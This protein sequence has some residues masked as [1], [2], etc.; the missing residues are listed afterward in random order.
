[1][2][3]RIRLRFSGGVEAICKLR[4]EEAAEK[5][6]EAAPFRSEANRWGDEIYFELPI[7]LNLRG[8]REV[9]EIG[10]VAYWPQGNSLCIFFG[11]TPVSKAGE[12]RAVS[13]VKPL[14]RV[15][16]GLKDLE[17]VEDGEMVE[18]EGLK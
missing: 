7:K 10:E 6:L 2:S 13:R 11:P 18:V 8:E 3:P 9:M 14:G 1:M 16:E 12:P 15:I 4:D 5:I 17:K